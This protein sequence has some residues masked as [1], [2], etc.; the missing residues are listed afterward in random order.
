MSTKQE[1]IVEIR[2]A[3]EADLVTF[4]KLIAPKTV[5]GSVHVELCDWWTRQDGKTHQLALLPRDHQK[6]RLM[7]Y[8]A[9]WHLTKHPEHRILYISST[10]NLAEKQLKFIKDI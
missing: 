9:A 4:I 5:L 7:G 3:A 1:K 6:S 10:A 8:R 2:E